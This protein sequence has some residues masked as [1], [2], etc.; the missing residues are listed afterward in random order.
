MLVTYLAFFHNSYTFSVKKRVLSELD[1]NPLADEQV[2]KKH[3]LPPA[4]VY[5]W[6]KNKKTIEEAAVD[7]D[8]RQRHRCPGAGRKPALSKDNEDFFMDWIMDERAKRNIVRRSA[9]QCCTRE[10]A[11]QQG[12]GQL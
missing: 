8:L 7:E 4:S 12:S 6:R 2:A 10:L 3:G 1:C 5:I 11:R 9:V